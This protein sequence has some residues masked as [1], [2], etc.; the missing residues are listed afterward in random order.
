MT[1]D[2]IEHEVLRAKFKEARI[3]MAIVCASIGCP[4]LRKEPYTGDLLSEQLDEQSRK[5]MSSSDKFRIDKENNVVYLSPI[6]DWFGE[7]FVKTY[8]PESGF[9]EYGARERAVLN[10]V[11]RYASDLES[12]H[13]KKEKYRIKYLEYDWSLNE[14]K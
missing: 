8:T 3:H 7:D 11:S 13:L 4:Y 6:F 2:A 9:E 1:L 14:Q 10:F 5:F 12:S